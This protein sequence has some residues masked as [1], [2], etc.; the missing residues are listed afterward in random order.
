MIHGHIFFRRYL[1]T[2]Q[3]NLS[4]F[5]ASVVSFSGAFQS[6]SS[7][8]ITQAMEEAS[9]T[10]AFSKQ[11]LEQILEQ[12]L[13]Q[14]DNLRGDNET[15]GRV[16]LVGLYII[17]ANDKD[18]LNLANIALQCGINQ[19]SL[20]CGDPPGQDCSRPPEPPTCNNRAGPGTAPFHGSGS[21][22]DRQNRRIRPS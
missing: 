2:D 19:S 12:I 11:F 18:K 5:T 17:A 6:W 14:M 4:I 7:E 16:G 22:H 8:R 15:K 1:L 10:Q 3:E 9:R 13:E 20:H 21:D